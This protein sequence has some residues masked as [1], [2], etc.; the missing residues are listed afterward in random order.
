MPHIKE[1]PVIIERVYVGKASLLTDEYG[2][3]DQ[4]L[5]TNEYF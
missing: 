5:K 3:Y 4:K 1:V 2:V